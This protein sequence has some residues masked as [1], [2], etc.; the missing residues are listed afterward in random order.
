MKIDKEIF[1]CHKCHSKMIAGK[2]LGSGSE[3][4]DIV[5]VGQNPCYPRCL[6]SGIV[7]TGG[8]GVILDNAL[9]AAGIT[10]EEVWI[11][12]VVK[13]A[14]YKNQCPTIEMRENCRSFLIEEFK[15]LKPKLVIVLGR[16][17]ATDFPENGYEV[18]RLYHPAYFLRLGKGRKFVKEFEKIIRGF[19]K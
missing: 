7:F 5:I 2:V 18:V 13:C 3:T 6:E 17:A 10:R 16:Y 8:S 19:Y 1:D 14:T 4:A 15:A 11:T 12:N 9:A